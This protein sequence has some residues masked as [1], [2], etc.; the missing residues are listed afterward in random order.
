ME[1]VPAPNVA[2]RI[3][4]N[5]NYF[6]LLPFTKDTNSFDVK[7]DDNVSDKG[8]LVGR[9][10]YSKPVIFQAP[11]FGALAGGGAQGAF[12]GTGAQK[13][14]SGGI[15]YNRIFQP[16]LIASSAWAWLTITTRR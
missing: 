10:S 15:N 2:Q 3:R 16:T 12:E 13:T 6:A 5:N 1:L 11:I 8:R 4:P 9:F 7:M 14:Y